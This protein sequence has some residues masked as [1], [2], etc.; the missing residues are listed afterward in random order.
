[1]TNTQQYELHSLRLIM[2]LGKNKAIWYCDV[3]I[4]IS[5]WS[6]SDERLL[7]WSNVKD[8]VLKFEL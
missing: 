1:M 3:M 6:G 4:Y 2:R 5:E 7:F 8:N